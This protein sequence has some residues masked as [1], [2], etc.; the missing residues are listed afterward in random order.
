[1]FYGQFIVTKGPLANVWLAS[2]L[3]HKLNKQTI[4]GT[5]IQSAVNEVIKPKVKH[6]INTILIL[7]SLQ[8]KLSLRTNGHLLLGIVRIY[9]KKAEYVWHE[10]EHARRF[11]A[12]FI[13]KEK[14]TIHRPRRVAAHGGI[15]ETA[16]PEEEEEQID[17]IV[18]YPLIY[19]KN[20][21]FRKDKWRRFCRACHP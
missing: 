11:F 12:H 5:N 14:R 8:V 2:H 9:A 18:S 20:Q 10:L 4:I 21:H 7:L 6:F 1:M 19:I 13:E 15:N 3:Q 17:I 16:I